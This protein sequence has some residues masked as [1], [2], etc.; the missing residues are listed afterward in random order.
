MG[1]MS[2]ELFRCGGT[3]GPDDDCTDPLTTYCISS[4]LVRGQA[5]AMSERSFKD[6]GYT[7]LSL[8]DCWM[9]G[10]NPAPDNQFIA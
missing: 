4:A 6:A 7:L 5:Q 10:R 3:N 9:S 8:D 1:F 2:W